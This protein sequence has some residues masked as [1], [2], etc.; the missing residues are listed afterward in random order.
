[1]KRRVFILIILMSLSYSSSAD[2]RDIP[3]CAS[4]YYDMACRSC[5]IDKFGS[6][7]E[8]C[9][10]KYMAL[11][12]KCVFMKYPFAAGLW[13]IDKCPSLQLCVDRLE[14][15]IA[16][17][18][19][20]TDKEYCRSYVCGSCYR[21][22]NKCSYR[23]SF[24]CEAE[25]VCG[26]GKCESDKG[27]KQSTCCKDCKCEGD[28]T[29]YQNECRSK[30]SRGCGPSSSDK[31]FECKTPITQ[32]ECGKAGLTH[33]AKT[34]ET[35]KFNCCYNYLG[36]VIK[37][38]YGVNDQESSRN[39]LSQGLEDATDFCFGSLLLPLL[40]PAGLLSAAFLLEL[41]GSLR[42]RRRGL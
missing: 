28:D 37:C 42:R 34:F 40:M 35:V 24:D 22:A 1:M 32:G 39:F 17:K 41:P 6:M 8:E 16:I 33:Y 26:D 2:S 12:K 11:V 5:P 3:P 9:Y 18:C 10:D 23:A 38:F 13:A 20:G 25:A 14:T 36:T 29:C 27:E 7:D 31:L 30:A 21:E 4:A 15:C 19:P